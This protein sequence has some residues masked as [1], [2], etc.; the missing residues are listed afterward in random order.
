MKFKFSTESIELIQFKFF[1]ISKSVVQTQ[2][3]KIE[4]WDFQEFVYLSSRH[5]VS[6]EFKLVQ[7][8][9]H[10]IPSTR[11]LRWCRWRSHDHIVWWPV[12]RRS[13]A[14]TCLTN[15]QAR[16][17]DSFLKPK[18]WLERSQTKLAYTKQH[19]PCDRAQSIMF[20]K[21]LRNKIIGGC[22]SLIHERRFV[23]DSHQ[24][25]SRCLNLAFTKWAKFKLSSNLLTNIFW[26][27]CCSIFNCANKLATSHINTKFLT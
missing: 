1:R 11:N 15:K 24:F 20:S 4:N 12:V 2:R 17:Q 26:N 22:N 16:N 7:L 25:C 23:R 19:Q 13:A 9:I 6:K 27:Q 10:N 8:K 21:Y 18:I 3:I 5:F 14:E